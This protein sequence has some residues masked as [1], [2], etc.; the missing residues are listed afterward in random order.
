M[1][2]NIYRVIWDK[3][4]K[5]PNVLAIFFRSNVVSNICSVTQ[6]CSYRQRSEQTNKQMAK[7]ANV[8]TTRGIICKTLENFKFKF[9][10]KNGGGGGAKQ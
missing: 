10:K 3:V 1:S 7:I 2:I 6:I 9:F 4:H 5:C 8:S